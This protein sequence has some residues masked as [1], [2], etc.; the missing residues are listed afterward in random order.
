MPSRH[1]AASR[2]YSA[3]RGGG[4]QTTC[5]FLYIVEWADL[6]QAD[7]QGKP[8]P[9]PIPQEPVATVL[10]DMRRERMEMLGRLPDPLTFS[11]AWKGPM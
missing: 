7:T 3:A 2:T 1:A 4:R 8:D 9:H 5:A 10:Y 6:Q 11:T